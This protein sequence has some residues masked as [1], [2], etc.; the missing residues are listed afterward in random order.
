[1]RGW[2][3]YTI[4]GDGATAGHRAPNPYAAPR[5]FPGRAS[6]TGI[7]AWLAEHIGRVKH[8]DPVGVSAAAGSARSPATAKKYGAARV[9]GLAARGH[10]ATHRHLGCRTADYKRE[11]W[12]ER[13]DASTPDA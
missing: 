6:H 9:I 5:R 7:S 13:I 11:D 12:L 10:A 3:E 1:M 4:V 8:R 2:Q